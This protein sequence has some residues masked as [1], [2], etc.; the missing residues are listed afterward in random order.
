M[1]IGQ[2]FDT[3]LIHSG[4][5]LKMYKDNY[6]IVDPVTGQTSVPWVFAGGDAATDDAKTVIE[7]IAAGERAAVG[8]DEYITGENHAFWRVDKKNDTFF[9]PDA[10]PAPFP[11]K[12]LPLI[13]VGRRKNNF[14]EVE[15]PWTEAEAVRQAA[16]CLRCDYG[17]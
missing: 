2:D 9:D 11:R 3:T 15:Q 6:I 12:H 1:A 16:R 14:D 17:H 5:E 8:M 13:D 10:D 4:T 7:A